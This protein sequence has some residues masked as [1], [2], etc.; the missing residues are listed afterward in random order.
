MFTIGM[1]I[2]IGQ[3]IGSVVSSATAQR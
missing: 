2:A 1:A 3:L